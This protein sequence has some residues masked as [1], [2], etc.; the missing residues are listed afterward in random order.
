MRNAVL[1]EMSRFGNH[2]FNFHMVLSEKTA[3]SGKHCITL[4]NGVQ[5]SDFVTW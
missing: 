4:Q 1:Q 5:K 2:D 3:T